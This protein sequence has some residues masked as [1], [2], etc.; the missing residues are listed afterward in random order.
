MDKE[1][2]KQVIDEHWD[3]WWLEGLSEFIKV[4]N[5]TTMVDKEYLSNGLV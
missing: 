4:P 3:S 2:T 1:K 5:L